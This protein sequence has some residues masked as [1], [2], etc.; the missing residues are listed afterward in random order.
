M[1]MT[2]IEETE[3]R[4]SEIEQEMIEASADY[5]LI[6]QLNDEKESLEAQYDKDITRWSELEEIIEQ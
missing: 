4:L 3:S 2:R 1:L 5:G 6:K